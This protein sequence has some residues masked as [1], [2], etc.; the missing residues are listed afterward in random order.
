MVN[1]RL[2][3]GA[4]R[5]LG[6]PGQAWWV[7]RTP[8]VK[9]EMLLVAM[10]EDIAQTREVVTKVTMQPATMKVLQKLLRKVQKE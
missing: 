8:Q 10:A 5:R 9:V 1:A 3:L 4:A 6:S 2:A 7:H